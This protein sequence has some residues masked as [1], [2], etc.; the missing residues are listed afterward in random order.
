MVTHVVG[1]RANGTKI[2]RN[3]FFNSDK[4]NHLLQAQSHFSKH[5]KKVAK[6]VYK[7]QLN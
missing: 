3:F 4:T 5:Q 7:Q 2:I 1:Q 6:L